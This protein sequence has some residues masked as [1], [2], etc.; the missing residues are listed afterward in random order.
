MHQISL[1]F[2]D[3]EPFKDEDEDGFDDFDHA[4]LASKSDGRRHH[5]DPT[6]RS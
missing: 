3:I 5:L 6:R 2:N 4:L 1:S